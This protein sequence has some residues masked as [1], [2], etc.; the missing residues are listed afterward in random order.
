MIGT[1]IVLTLMLIVFL[2]V[3]SIFQKK[4]A[5]DNERKT[6]VI[7]TQSKNIKFIDDTITLAGDFPISTN[8]RV[9][10]LA[11]KLFSIKMII[12]CSPKNCHYISLHK[13]TLL[14]LQE[15][16]LLES[17]KGLPVPV[18]ES[19]IIQ[20]IKTLRRIDAILKIEVKR[21]EY[22]LGFIENEL[23][24]TAFF[25]L[26]LKANNFITLANYAYDNGSKGTARDRFEAAIEL[27]SNSNTSRG[28]DWIESKIEFCKNRLQSLQNDMRESNQSHIRLVKSSNE[29]DNGLSRMFDHKKEKGLYKA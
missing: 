28:Q 27:L 13:E 11:R 22:S 19:H 20:M 3:M 6:E 7:E 17:E 9:I 2:T 12:E 4:K 8:T 23:S 5:I 25:V 26:Y 15:S 10:L 29:D 21:R 14:K 18:N 1:L 24:Q 16:K